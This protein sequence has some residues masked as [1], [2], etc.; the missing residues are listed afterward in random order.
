VSPS[1]EF[2][3]RPGGAETDFA[4][5]EQGGEKFVHGVAFASAGGLAQAFDGAVEAG[6]DGGVADVVGRGE[7]LEGARPQHELGDEIQIL[8]REFVERVGIRI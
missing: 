5:F 3:D 6:A 2:A 1:D 7:V 8:A 4:T